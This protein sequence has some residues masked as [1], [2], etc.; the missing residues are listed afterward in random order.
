M[1]LISDLVLSFSLG[2]GSHTSLSVPI[3]LIPVLTGIGVV[4]WLTYKQHVHRYSSR[5]TW[6]LFS[7]L[8]IVLLAV[9]NGL[10]PWFDFAQQAPLTAQVGGAALFIF[11][12]LTFLLV[13]TQIHEIRWLKW[14]VWLFLSIGSIYI[15]SWFN[16]NLANLASQYLPY[17]VTG[18]L[19][20]V[21]LVVLSFSQ[22]VYNRELKPIF[23][24]I[25]LGLSCAALYIGF[26]RNIGW[27]SGWLPAFGSSLGCHIYP[28]PHGLVYS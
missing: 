8:V 1:L 27:T 16:S 3:L 11:S 18:A 22:S 13:G 15:L 7:L 12:I 19:F 23:R 26:F 25:L 21:W 2:T 6:P 20:W 28:L 24:F 4:T 5:T 14:L 10:L 17:G 9:I